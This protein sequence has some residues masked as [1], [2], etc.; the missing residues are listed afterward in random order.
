MASAAETVTASVPIFSMVTS[1][2][3]PSASGPTPSGVP[4]AMMSPG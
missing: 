2:R 4:V 1:I 3:S